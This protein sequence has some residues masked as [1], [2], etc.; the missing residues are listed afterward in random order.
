LAAITADA[1]ANPLKACQL[2]GVDV[3][4]VARLRPLV[5]ADWLSGLQVPKSLLKNQAQA[6]MA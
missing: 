4:H 3:D 6:R 5:P 1:M 2:L